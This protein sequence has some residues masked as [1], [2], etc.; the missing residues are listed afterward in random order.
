M[1]HVHD[2]ESLQLDRCY[3][4]IG[5]FDGVHLGHQSLIRNMRQEAQAADCPTVVLTFFPHPSVVL[6]GR[7]PSYYIT[8]PDEKAELLGNLGVDVVV[9]HPFDQSVARIR[10]ADFVERVRR[11]LGMRAL[12]AGQDFALGYQREGGL[13]FLR[14]LGESQGFDVHEVEAFVV[15]GEVISSTRVREAL[16]IGDVARAGRYLGRPFAV[17]GEVVRGAGR[18]RALG[19][20]T[21]NLKIW[22]ERAIPARGV[23]AC[24]ALVEGQRWPAVTNIGVRPTFDSG[25]AP[26]VEA[27]LLG[28]DR[29]LYGQ[30][31]ELEF[32]DRLRDEMKFP[33]AEA[34]V[35]QI[36]VDVERAK[37]VLGD[38][39]Y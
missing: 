34:L 5:A 1:R 3:V 22:E 23:Y 32:V 33:G 18:G 35:A 28:F 37:Q 8:T 20:P 10:A 13:S 14:R 2:L 12:W 39:A 16:R 17:P 7:R 4:A 25:S 38:G 29:D 26:A 19:I 30:T 24:W 31:I 9:T 36:R 27:H 15:E 11:H 6:G 21:A